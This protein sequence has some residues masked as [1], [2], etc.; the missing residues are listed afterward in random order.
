L[1]RQKEVFEDYDEDF[2]DYDEDFE[3]F[4]ED[5]EAYA[6]SVADVRMNRH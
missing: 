4:K 2:E 3:D 6:L 1:T 5:F